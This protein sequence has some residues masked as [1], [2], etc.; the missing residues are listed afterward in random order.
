MTLSAIIKIV[1]TEIYETTGPRSSFSLL[2]SPLTTA[3]PVKGR[4]GLEPISA[5]SGKG[6]GQR[7]QVASSSQG[8]HIET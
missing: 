5:S 8:R 3:Y 6:G 2:L 7:G 4:R 1:A